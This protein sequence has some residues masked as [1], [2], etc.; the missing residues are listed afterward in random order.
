M[1]STGQSG[2]FFHFWWDI[3][4]IHMVQR[5]YKKACIRLPELSL[6][7]PWMADWQSMGRLTSWPHYVA[8]FQKMD[9]IFYQRC[10]PGFNT[11]NRSIIV[12]MLLDWCHTKNRTAYN[13][14]QFPENNSVGPPCNLQ[15]RIDWWTNRPSTARGQLRQ[16]GRVRKGRRRRKRRLCDSG[17]RREGG[18]RGK[19]CGFG[20]DEEKY[21]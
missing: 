11:G 3:H 17:R 15:L 19:N 13:I 14:P 6:N 1:G 2:L 4:P 20:K 5:F 12:F 9:K 18:P 8:K 10:T 21:E 7:V 16:P